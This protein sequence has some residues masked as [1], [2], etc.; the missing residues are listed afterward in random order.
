METLAPSQKILCAVGAIVLTCQEI[1]RHLKFL[2]PF[3]N[4]DD[5]TAASVLARHA[6]LARRSLG[7][8]AG[9][10]VGAMSGDIEA[11]ESHVKQVVSER[12]ELVHHFQERY[13]DT[14]ARAGHDELLEALR[15]QHSRALLLLRALREM[16]LAVAETMRDSVFAGTPEEGEI[17]KL[18]EGARASLAS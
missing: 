4:A 7:K 11:L 14:L 9:Q 5:P 8:V 1:E 13:G 3:M 18:C 12:N 15:A 17:A 6:K 2:V 16:A 10:F